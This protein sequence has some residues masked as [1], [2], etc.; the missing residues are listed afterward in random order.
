MRHKLQSFASFIA[1]LL[2]HEMTFLL[3]EQKFKD[4]EKLAILRR[5]HELC[6]AVH[7]P[8]K[9][10][11][12]H[13]DKRKYS[14]V[15]KW[16]EDKLRETD[17]DIRFE[18]M[19]ELERKVVT[20][21]I[22]PDEEQA[23]LRALKQVRPTD[24]FFV[25]SYE[26][27]QRFSHFLLIRM[28]FS[29]Y[30]TV[31]RFL[32]DHRMAWERSAETFARLQDATADIVNQ[33]ASGSSDSKQWID[34]LESVFTD[35][36]LDGQNRYYAFVRLIF[37][38]LNYGNFDVLLEKFEIQDRLFERGVYYSKRLL[39]N[40]YGQRLLLHSKLKDYAQ[41]EYYGY[42]SLRGHNSDY[43][44][45]L[46]NLVAV[47]LRNHHRAE[48]LALMK[49]AMTESRNTRSFYNRIGFVS[50]YMR[51]L[52][53]E[54]MSDSAARYGAAFLK[55][56]YKKILDTRWHLF[57]TAYLGALFH[58]RK[59]AQ[60]VSLARRYQLQTLDAQ[61]A[62]HKENAYLPVIPWY[63]AFAE[64]LNADNDYGHLA[65]RIQKD[66][67]EA[68]NDPDRLERLQEFVREAEQTAP[69]LRGLVK[70]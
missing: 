18:W 6:S 52:T 42:L 24:Y 32:T 56:W 48:A 23:L 44:F 31:E 57:F 68:R 11:A 19:N 34:W 16:I 28:R 46:N 38:H 60:M 45:Y 12:S 64:Y 27:A 61:Y 15:K 2:P 8:D 55:A 9:P 30:R 49:S 36:T 7:M 37:A 13:I 1:T 70:I 5:A 14:A 59:Y 26:L 40:Y 33:Y 35:D 50:F 66:V 69:G 25:K 58:T 65:A 43:I 67:E 39:L 21:S 3:R 10:F 20:D 47:M 62:R 53:L 17:A 4:A 22:S 63:I 51:C 54:G 29:E 41:A